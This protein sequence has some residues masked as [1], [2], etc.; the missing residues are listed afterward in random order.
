MER[1]KRTITRF[2][3]LWLPLLLTAW[4]HSAFE[5]KKEPLWWE[6]RLVLTA[7]G[8]YRT[9]EGETR[10]SGEYQLGILWTGTMERDADDFRLFHAHS[11]I[12]SWDAKETADPPQSGKILTTREFEVCPEFRMQYILKKEG[13]L[14]FAFLVSGFLAPRS[15]STNKLFIDLPA[16]AENH[17]PASEIDYGSHITHGSNRI[18]LDEH[19]ILGA[20]FEKNFTWRWAHQQWF[21][22][23]EK[24]V[25]LSNRHNAEV[26]IS[27]ES[28]YK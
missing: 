7:E 25:F 27:I 24:T 1:T 13:L 4:T 6:I 9:Q 17:Q 3:V 2:L 20:D 21:L 14:H 16:S 28:H 5:V 18:S 22:K 26:N 11:K 8:E 23:H 12:L 19:A 10:Y 15:A